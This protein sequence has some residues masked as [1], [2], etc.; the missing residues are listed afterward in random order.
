MHPWGHKVLDRTER[1]TL[2]FSPFPLVNVCSVSLKEDSGE[3]LTLD[4][5]YQMI[6]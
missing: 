6:G 5:G 3:Q 4:V 1:L 2:S